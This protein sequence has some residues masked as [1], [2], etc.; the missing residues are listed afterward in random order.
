MT[1]LA[2]L[3]AIPAPSDAIHCSD[4]S[5]GQRWFLVAEEHVAGVRVGVDGMQDYTGAV[6]RKVF[7][8]GGRVELSAAEVKELGVALSRLAAVCLNA[9]DELQ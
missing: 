7:L 6:E 1:P 4:W 3:D 8:D 9:A 5:D 2:T